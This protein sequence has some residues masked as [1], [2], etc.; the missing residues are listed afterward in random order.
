M[1]AI[2]LHCGAHCIVDDDV[3]DALNQFT[4]YLSP[5]GYAVR[6]AGGK[7][8]KTEYMHRLIMFA[9]K[10][11]DVDHISLDKLDN[12]RENLRLA[13]RSQNCFNRD[14][15][16]TNRSGFK[17]VSWDKSKKKWRVA[18]SAFNKQYHIGRFD[19]IEDAV[20]A[21]QEA[22]KKHHGEFARWTR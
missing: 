3:F 2:I 21:H 1:K 9:P 15:Q 18:I 13:S 17:G 16:S 8:K 12:R 22:V 10:G 14:K 19:S 7:G 11:V 20:A 6:Y 5:Y 4:W